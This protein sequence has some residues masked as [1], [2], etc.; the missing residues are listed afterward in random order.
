MPLSGMLMGLELAR[1]SFGPRTKLLL[2]VPRL[3]VPFWSWSVAVMVAPFTPLAV[4]VNGLVTDAPASL[5]YC[6]TLPEI[7]VPNEYRLLPP[8]PLTKYGKP[9]IMTRS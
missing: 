7:G 5:L 6:F 8:R 4:K 3:A 1:L 2:T 9:L